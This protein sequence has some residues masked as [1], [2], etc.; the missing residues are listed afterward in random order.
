[1]NTSSQSIRA[2]ALAA[3]FTVV[4]GLGVSTR[5]IDAAESAISPASVADVDASELRARINTILQEHVYLAT[6]A[7]GA[8]L[9]GRQAQFEAAAQAL[10]ANSVELSKLIGSVYGEGAEAAFLALWR[11]HIGFFV[12]YTTGLA[13]G[14]ETRQ[15]AAIESL[16]GYANDFAAF[17]SSANPYLP[18][19]AVVD[20]VK[21]HAVTLKAVIKAQAAGDEVEAYTALRKAAAHMR[22][23]ADPLAGAIAQQFPEKFAMDR[24]GK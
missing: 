8:A 5:P 19:D 15:N 10:D 16:L 17:L 7:T 11:K 24:M 3:I 6:S 2:A 4:L 20:L 18:K 22:M 12:D 21:T 9:G 14:D 13:T 23:I 1:M